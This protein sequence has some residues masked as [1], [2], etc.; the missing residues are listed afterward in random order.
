MKKLD[1]VIASNSNIS[2]VKRMSE[3]KRIAQYIKDYSCHNEKLKAK[4]EPDLFLYAFELLK[5][6]NN[7]ITKED[8]LIFEDSLAGVEGAK[9]TGIKIA[10]ITNSYNEE[11]LKEKGADI[12]I[13][14]IGEIFNYIELC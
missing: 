11:T 1:M 6:Y 13:N 14:N 2:Y 4:P 12:V 3:K 9:K 10:A 8:T 5:K 7:S